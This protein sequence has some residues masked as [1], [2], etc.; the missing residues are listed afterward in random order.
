MLKEKVLS[1][2]LR[3]CDFVS[4]RLFTLALF[5]WCDFAATLFLLLLYKKE[6]PNVKIENMPNLKEPSLQIVNH[7]RVMF[8]VYCTFFLFRTGPSLVM[9]QNLL[10]RCSAAN[11]V[12]VKN[13]SDRNNQPTHI[14]N[15]NVVSTF[16]PSAAPSMAKLTG[17][18]WFVLHTLKAHPPSFQ[19]PHN[20]LAP[21]S[22]TPS[23]IMVTIY[24]SRRLV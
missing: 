24:V 5:F 18:A 6:G 14:H 2:R 15:R 12:Q 16:L 21:P 9:F 10:R 8:P 7:S 17:K 19:P 22:H 23:S 1:D 4:R 13:L 11:A 3:S 20:S